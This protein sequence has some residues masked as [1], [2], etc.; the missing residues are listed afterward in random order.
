MLG[1]GIGLIGPALST[2]TL[3]DVPLTEAGSASGVVGA[4]QQLAAVAALALVGGL[5]FA[6]QLQAQDRLALHQ[7]LTRAATGLVLL[8]TL[9]AAAARRLRV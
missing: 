7:G 6:G 5:M 9:G 8:L 1:L 4:V 3:K 2:A